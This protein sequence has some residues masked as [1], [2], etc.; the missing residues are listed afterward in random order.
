MWKCL[1]PAVFLMAS[2]GRLHWFQNSPSPIVYEYEKMTLLL[3][4]LP[5]WTFSDEFMVSGDSFK[6]PSQ[7][8]HLHFFK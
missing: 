8:P 3:D 5:Q 1:E 6:S 2:R 7:Q 4:L